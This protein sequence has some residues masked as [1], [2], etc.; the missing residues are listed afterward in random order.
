[1]IQIP[2][3]FLLSRVRSVSGAASSGAASSDA[4]A[5]AAAYAFVPLA[6]DAAEGFFLRGIAVESSLDRGARLGA[7]PL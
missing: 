5:A 2:V 4:A 7:L 6:A 3:L 1:M